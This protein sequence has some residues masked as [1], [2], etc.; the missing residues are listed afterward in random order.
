MGVSCSEFSKMERALSIVHTTWRAEFLKEKD[1][2][3]SSSSLNGQA[4]ITVGA[5][6]K[7]FLKRSSP[8]ISFPFSL[9][10][11]HESRTRSILIWEPFPWTCYFD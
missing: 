8:Q 4:L 9:K 10:A 1:L 3:M 7:I 2:K 5:S 6:T 11:D